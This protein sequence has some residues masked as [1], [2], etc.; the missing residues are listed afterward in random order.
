MVVITQGEFLMDRYRSMKYR[1]WRHPSEMCR[2]TSDGISP[3]DIG[4]RNIASGDIPETLPPDVMPVDVG[5]RNIASGDTRVKS[6]GRRR[7]TFRRPTKYRKWRRTIKGKCETE[8]LNEGCVGSE[9][10][11]SVLRKSRDFC[12]F[13]RA[14]NCLG[15]KKYQSFCS[16]Y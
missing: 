1:K 2:P 15:P 7:T 13:S 16:K 11:F 3:A 14:C 12:I 8:I 6:A 10:D 5:R 4:R 9:I